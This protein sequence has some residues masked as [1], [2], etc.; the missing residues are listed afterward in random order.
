ML[1][2]RQFLNRTAE[3]DDE[4]AS[5][6]LPMG[7][8]VTDQEVAKYAARVLAGE[9]TND[10]FPTRMSDCTFTDSQRCTIRQARAA[11]KTAH[12]NDKTPPQARVVAKPPQKST[13]PPASNTRSPKPL[14]KLRKL[15]YLQSDRCFFCG[16]PLSEVD[17]SIEH[18]IPKSRGGKSDDGNEVVC[19]KSLNET[20]G[21]M[22]VKGKF[23]F[24]L[25]S[26]GCFK[27]PNS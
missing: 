19:H 15:L 8:A 6:E 3:S 1:E 10:I 25:K 21:D 4:P 26:V 17:A 24:V 18:L 2:N 9:S 22:D 12:K 11:R 20:F 5:F 7:H 13:G 14:S 16:E 27:C 23:A